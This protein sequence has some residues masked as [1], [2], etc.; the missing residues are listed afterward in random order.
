MPNM[1]IPTPDQA[2]SALFGQT[3]R[4]VLALLFGRPQESFYLRQIA[5][6]TGAGTGAVQRELATLLKGGLIRR[7]PRGNQVHFSANPES[8]LFDELQSLMAKSTGI[9]DVLRSALLRFW[10]SQMI[11]SAFIYGSVALGNQRSS[12]DIDLMVV[13]RLHLKDLAPVL[14][15]VERRLG[16]EINPVIYRPED[17]RG[18]LS[19]RAHFVTQVMSR[20]KIM[21][22]GNPD[23]LEELAA[24]SLAHRARAQS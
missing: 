15:K 24:E 16:R 23:D 17:L 20:P 6:E 12:S 5:R 2:A 22:F 14:R 7:A 21:L 9:A 4:H 1:I 18:G 13:G 11:M 8:P 3:R 10:N 19:K